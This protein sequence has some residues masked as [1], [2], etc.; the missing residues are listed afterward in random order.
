MANAQN[1]R[2]DIQAVSVV[3]ILCFLKSSHFLYKD[4]SENTFIIN[5]Y[6]VNKT[7]IQRQKIFYTL[8]VSRSK[9]ATIFSN[10]YICY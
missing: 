3:P 10:I 5:M 1:A 4:K 2:I 8:G 7:T 6:V 9:V